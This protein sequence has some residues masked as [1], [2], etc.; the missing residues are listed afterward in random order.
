MLQMH[1]QTAWTTIIAV[2]TAAV[3][4]CVLFVLL[5]LLLLLLLLSSMCA[6]ACL[7][8]LVSVCVFVCVYGCAHVRVRM[9]VRV[10]ACVC[11]CLCN[12]L[13]RRVP[14]A[15]SPRLFQ[16]A[17]STILHA[18]SV[19]ESLRARRRQ[20]HRVTKSTRGY[21]D[22]DIDVWEGTSQMPCHKS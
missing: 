12:L 13:D 6:C 2:A 15:T 1:Y 20:M 4:A 19:L 14:I 5:L 9:F 10:C 16:A 17:K 11:V 21:N 7:Y 3:A 8:D 18:S 22:D